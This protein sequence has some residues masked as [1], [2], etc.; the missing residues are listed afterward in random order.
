MDTSKCAPHTKSL[1]EEGGVC[2]SCY[3]AKTLKDISRGINRHTNHT[4]TNIDTKKKQE[5]WEDIHN[6]MSKKNGCKSEMCWI[7]DNVI[8]KLSKIVIFDIRQSTFKPPMPL[9]WNTNKNEWLST[10]DILAVMRQHETNIPHF[11]FHG[12]TPIDFHLKGENGN[13][14]VD[15]LCKINL[16]ELIDSG[17]EI[18]GIVFNTDPHNKSGQHWISMYIDLFDKSCLFSGGKNKSKGSKNR[19]HK[20]LLKKHKKK[21]NDVEKH[22]VHKIADGKIH[23]KE[24]IEYSQQDEIQKRCSGMYYFDSQGLKPPDNVVKLMEKLCKQGDNCNIKFQKLYNNIQHQK[25]NTECGIY[26]IHFITTML[27]GNTFKEYIK[28]IRGDDYMEKLRREL[29]IPQEFIN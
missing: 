12:P 21:R 5:L 23:T 25:G 1:E 24:D 9:S 13:C 4:I 2:K 10:T 6:V 16:R 8:D 20:K 11:K 22:T 27:K 19:H 3:K 18:I 28:N 14:M 7:K 26:S 15:D 29:Y 17:I